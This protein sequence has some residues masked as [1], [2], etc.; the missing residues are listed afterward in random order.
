MADRGLLY[1]APGLVAGRWAGDDVIGRATAPPRIVW[2]EMGRG[3]GLEGRYG[4]VLEC[5]GVGE[6]GERY[7]AG[8]ADQGVAAVDLGPVGSLRVA[9]S[10]PRPEFPL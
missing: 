6:P 9:A 2:N 8:C 3:L 5:L 7:V 10:S 1:I 4:A